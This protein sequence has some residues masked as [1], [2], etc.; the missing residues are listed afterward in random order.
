MIAVEAKGSI[1]DSLGP[2]MEVHLALHSPIRTRE[3][4]RD[5]RLIVRSANYDLHGRKTLLELAKEPRARSESS[6]QP[7]RL[8]EMKPRS[9]N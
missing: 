8:A 9:S 5:S 7:H 2:K 1:G 3:P 6:H 4:M